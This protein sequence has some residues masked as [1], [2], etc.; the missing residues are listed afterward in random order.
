QAAPPV[1]DLPG[2]QKKRLG[3]S[4]GAFISAATSKAGRRMADLL[5]PASGSSGPGS[6]WASKKAPGL[7][8]RRV[9]L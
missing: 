2:H 8:L 9:Y 7:Q 5:Q 1:L 3:F 6:P 4:C